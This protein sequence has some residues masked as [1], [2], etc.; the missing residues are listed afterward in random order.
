ML[1]KDLNNNINIVISGTIGVGKTIVSKNLFKN[2]NK[3]R[4]INEIYLIDEIKNKDPY[5]ELYYKNRIEWSFLT[6]MNFLLNRFKDSYLFTE[7]NG[8]KI[9]DRHFLDDYIFSSAEIIKESIPNFLL[10]SYFLINNELNN[11]INNLSKVDYLFLLKADFDVIYERIK[12]RNLNFEQEINIEYWRDIYNQYYNNK[13]IFKY[14]KENC[15]NF[16]IINTNNKSVDKI[17]KEIIKTM[18]L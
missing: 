17:T 9:F 5:L 1:K 2:L 18:N 14:L 8:I 12:K 10:E 4:K 15:K 13:N 11:K 7:K 6:Q 16:N 3:K